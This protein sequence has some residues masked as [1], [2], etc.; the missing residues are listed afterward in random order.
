MTALNHEGRA[1]AAPRRTAPLTCVA[2]AAGLLSGARAGAFFG[3]TAP[4]AAAPA[5]FAAPAVG[6]FPELPADAVF[7]V[8]AVRVAVTGRGVVFVMGREGV[9]DFGA[10]EAP[11]AGRFRVLIMC[12]GYHMARCFR[13]RHGLLA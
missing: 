8:V 1:G 13:E 2:V 6:D 12:S 10:A 4:F 3:A 9:P 7:G 5:G 11:F